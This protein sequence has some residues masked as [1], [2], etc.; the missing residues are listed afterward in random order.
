MCRV[1]FNVTV[2]WEETVLGCSCPQMSNAWAAQRLRDLLG[3]RGI[4]SRN[5][6]QALHVGL[7]KLL[8]LRFELLNVVFLGISRI[9]AVVCVPV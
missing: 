8:T 4:D 6:Q 7:G 9:M 3:F 5:P 2:L 1:S